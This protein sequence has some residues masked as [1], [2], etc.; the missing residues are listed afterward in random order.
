MTA[1]ATVAAAFASITYKLS[2]TISPADGGA[3]SVTPVSST[4]IYAGGARV[5]LTEVP[6][7]G[8]SFSRWV[9]DV[10]DS[11]GC[12]LMTS[13]RAITAN[14]TWPINTSQG[15][16]TEL[17]QDLLDQTPDSGAASWVIQID[18]GA[19]TR[20]QVGASV[21]AGN[22]IGQSGLYL[23]KIYVAILGRDPD[24]AGWWSWFAALRSGMTQGS[25]RDAFISS[26]EFTA[27]YGAA[28][29]NT[30]FVTLI[31]Q[32]ILG[33][34]PDSVGL[35]YWTAQLQAGVSR[36]DVVGAFISSPEFDDAVRPRCYANLL[37]L[38]FLRRT[39]EAAGLASWTR[40]LST[41]S[42]L[43]AAVST[44]ITSR[45]YLSRFGQ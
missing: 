27:N 9:G 13:D 29:S 44:F 43:P 32:N 8:W 33:R 42:N 35:Q 7:S 22:G 20:A 31:Y 24:F 45:E 21:M 41:D 17:Y 28:V 25:I 16:V 2:V 34:P 5:C 4:G 39:A 1:N 30:M 14:F 10:P 19:M 36:G 12:T 18:S 23:I 6:A 3:V 40:S 26:P 37:Y 38:G 15:F 11:S